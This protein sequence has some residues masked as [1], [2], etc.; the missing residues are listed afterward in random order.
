M[1]GYEEIEKVERK[2]I[3]NSLYSWIGII[4]ALCVVGVVFT[5]AIKNIGTTIMGIT[6]K[7]IYITSK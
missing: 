2:Y 1:E 4:I 5:L 7:S 6:L 3:N